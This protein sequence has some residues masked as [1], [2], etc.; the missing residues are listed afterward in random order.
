MSKKIKKVKK[1]LLCGNRNLRS[2]FDVGNLYVSNF[3]ERKNIFKGTKSK[4]NLLYCSNCTLI[5]LS[6]LAPQEIMYRRFYWYKSGVTKTMREGLKELFLDCE[7]KARLKKTDVV[8]DIGANDGTL[9]KYFKSKKY[10]TIGCEPANNLKSE[11]KKNCNYVINNFWSKKEFLK[12]INKNRLKKPK[13]ITAIGMFYD[14]EDPNKFIKDAAESLDDNGIFVAQLMSFKS[15]I[16]KNDLGNI[17][18]EHIEFYSFKSIKYLFEKNGLEIFK[19]TSND[20]NGG[21]HRFY[22]R[23]FKNG[24]IKLPKENIL[25]MMKKFVYRVK[26]NKRVT[27]DF[28]KKQI[29]KNKKI[30]LYGASTKGNTVL[31]Y[32]GLN[33]RIIPYAAERT[34]FKWGK[35]T[36]G[37]GI[38]IIS[39]KEAK[40]LK[41]DFF[42]VTPWGFIKEFIKREKNWLNNGGK[43]IL[44]FPKMKI[45]GKK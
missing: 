7:K 23:K 11:L 25:E 9:L 15:M 13:L 27:L 20:I 5:Q 14:L 19:I 3:V 42:F 2:L 35:Y 8:L 31:Q 1:C 38:K 12:I 21:S 34:S 18:H 36:I 28:I 6:H 44:P 17:C 16:E 32:Y 26:K 22:C 41:P 45:I 43:F 10:K 33:N 40:K 4:L 39:E 37:T 30:F 29:K 24:S